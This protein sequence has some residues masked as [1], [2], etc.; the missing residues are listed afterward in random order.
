M[1]VQDACRQTGLHLVHVLIIL[2]R[3]EYLIF[4]GQVIVLHQTVNIGIHLLLLHVENDVT[5]PA[6]ANQFMID[7]PYVF[8]NTNEPV[9]FF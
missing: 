2:C 4:L 8:G 6:I 7:D 5:S 9:N 1:G 3:Y